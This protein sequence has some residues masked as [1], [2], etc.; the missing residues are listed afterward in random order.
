[1]FK[2]LK[3]IY[4]RLKIQKNRKAN[5]ILIRA[6]I[7]ILVNSKRAFVV[8]MMSMQRRM[9]YCNKVLFRFLDKNTVLLRKLSDVK[10]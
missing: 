7:C 10:L 4:M 8:V 5:Y 9:Q 3:N 6:S 2:K 1:M